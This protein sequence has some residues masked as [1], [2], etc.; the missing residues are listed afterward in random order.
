M[1]GKTLDYDSCARWMSLAVWAAAR[2][3]QYKD[4]VPSGWTD[5]GLYTLFFHEIAV[6]ALNRGFSL[7]AGNR[8]YEVRRML[9]AIAPLDMHMRTAFDRID[10]ETWLTRPGERGKR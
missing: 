9:Y 8:A 6:E 4:K 5:E 3:Q 7:R 2:Y 10:R 1:S